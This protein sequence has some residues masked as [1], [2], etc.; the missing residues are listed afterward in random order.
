M[1]ATTIKEFY[2][3][4]L[5]EACPE[6][7]SFLTERVGKDI[8]NFNVFDISE[9]YR[10]NKQ[11]PKM[12]YNRRS[13]YK[14][15]LIHGK[16]KVEYA[17]KTL[18]IKTCAILFASPK[19]PYHYLPLDT[20][21]RG[22]FCV[23]TTDF[24]SKSTI[25]MDIDQLP[26]FSSES[27]FV[28]QISNDE[29]RVAEEVFIKM[30]REMSS[31][32]TYKYDLLRNLLM[33]LV[34]FGQKL[35]PIPTLDT[36]KTAASRTT[37]LFIELLEAQFPLDNLSQSLQMKVPADYA[38]VLGVHVN[39][40][41]R[42]LKET[43]GRTTGEIIRGR[44]FQEAKILLNQTHWNVSEIAFALGFDE[45]SSFSHF[46]KKFSGQSPNGYRLLPVV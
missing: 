42:V 32:Y 25:G 37:A 39:H 17:D 16:N 14:V 2:Q 29:Y 33:E 36:T 9:L 22:Y 30:R 23:F 44:I 20:D 18:E 46:F 41:N 5:G 10:M 35:R 1:S 21:Q 13:Y 45:L 31:D 43:T 26:I 28:F 40:L 7:T 15:S 19:V 27:D 24:I 12:P 34:H 11:G 4:I 3:H 8:G 6:V 38:K